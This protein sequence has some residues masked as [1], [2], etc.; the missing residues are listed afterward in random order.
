MLYQLVVDGVVVREAE[1]I[2]YL[3]NEFYLALF[4][5]KKVWIEREG[6]KIGFNGRKVK[7]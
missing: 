2:M 4:E 7:R 6:Q 3:R 1:K 5:G